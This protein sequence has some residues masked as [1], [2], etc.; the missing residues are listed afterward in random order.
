ME[1]ETKHSPFNYVIHMV[2]FIF[3]IINDAQQVALAFLGACLK[4]YQGTGFQLFREFYVLTLKVQA[5][6]ENINFIVPCIIQI[7][8]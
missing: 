6:M 8:E 5:M 1:W 4:P 3:M 7:E 2:K